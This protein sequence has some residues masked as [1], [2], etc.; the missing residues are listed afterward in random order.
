[1]TFENKGRIADIT[2]DREGNFVAFIG[3][4]DDGFYSG[5]QVVDRKTYKRQSTAIK[6]CEKWINS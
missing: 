5:M 1:M 3:F 4:K 6:F 2:A